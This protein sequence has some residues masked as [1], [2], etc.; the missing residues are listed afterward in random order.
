MECGFLAASICMALNSILSAITAS[1]WHSPWPRC[2][3]KARRRFT[4]RMRRGGRLPRLFRNWEKG[5]VDT[6][7]GVSEVGN[8]I[9]RLFFALVGLGGKDGNQCHTTTLQDQ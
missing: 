6:L 7:R 8:D 9:R 4:A 1:P 2:A 5:P 3:R